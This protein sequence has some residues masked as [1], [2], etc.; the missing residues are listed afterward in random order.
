VT[1]KVEREKI[2]VSRSRIELL[3]LLAILLVG[4]A[5]WGV[6]AISF[7]RS[8]ASSRG[9]RPVPVK[10]SPGTSRSTSTAQDSPPTTGINMAEFPVVSTI[11][12]RIPT[13]G[14]SVVANVILTPPT[15]NRALSEAT[16]ESDANPHAGLGLTFAHA[17][18]ADITEPDTY[19][20]SATTELPDRVMTYQQTISDLPVWVVS[21]HFTTPAIVCTGV[22]SELAPA[23]PPQCTAHYAAI[24][25]DASSGD[26]VVRLPY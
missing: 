9:L 2:L 6:A 25:I 22:P 14:I 11:P 26:F 8:S 3:A 10:T 17:V 4:L 7:G 20:P 15:G 21:Y 5:A 24:A 19:L 23:L 13:S 18:P 12:G 1:E 16:E